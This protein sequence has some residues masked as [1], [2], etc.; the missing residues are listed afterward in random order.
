MVVPDAITVPKQVRGSNKT[1]NISNEEDNTKWGLRVIT[2]AW[3]DGIPKTA[4]LLHFPGGFASRPGKVV[5]RWAS[6]SAQ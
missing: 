6:Q 2:K 4:G 5:H 3:H 1:N